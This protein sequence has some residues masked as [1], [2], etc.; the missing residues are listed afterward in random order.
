MIKSD[1]IK[2]LAKR[3]TDLGHADVKLALNLIFAEMAAVLAA[4]KRI[5]IRGFG[6]F[7]K[8]VRASR[9]LRNPR[10]GAVLRVEQSII[11][12]FKP[13]AELRDRVMKRARSRV[14]ILSIRQIAGGGVEGGRLERHVLPGETSEVV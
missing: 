2:R 4:G 3:H 1:F 14:G 7:S 11:I 10:T 8:R 5:E 13:G 9:T 12:H 6:V